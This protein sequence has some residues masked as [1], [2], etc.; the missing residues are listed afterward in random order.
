LSFFSTNVALASKK[1][2][3][4]KVHNRNPIAATDVKRPKIVERLWAS[5]LVFLICVG[6]GMEL[7][8]WF[9][10]VEWT[11]PYNRNPKH[12]PLKKPW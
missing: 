5:M 6:D 9:S 4:L 7:F 3:E 1:V 10:M 8:D 11:Y 12:D 2:V